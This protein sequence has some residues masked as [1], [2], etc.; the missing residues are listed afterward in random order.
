MLIVVA[1]AVAA[2]AVTVAAAAAVVVAV[3]V[4]V[5]V[6]VVVRDSNEAAEAVGRIESQGLYPDVLTED[7]LPQARY[8]DP[9]STDFCDDAPC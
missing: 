6:V 1:V 7:E 3:V 4:V 9:T 8:N 2:V 5:V